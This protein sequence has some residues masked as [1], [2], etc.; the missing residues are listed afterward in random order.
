MLYDKKSDNELVAAYMN[1]DKQAFEVLLSRHKNKVYNYILSLVKDKALADD[2]FRDTHIKIVNTL[3]NGTY[4]D[5]GK[6]IQW[7]MRIA[8]NLVID[9]FRRSQRFPTVRTD[10]NFD[11]F[12][13]LGNSEESIEQKIIREQI[14]SDVKKLIRQ[15]PE[16]QRKVLIMRHYSNMS[17]K[18]IADK[19]DV[20]INT[21]L[22]RMRY[23]LINLRRMAEEKTTLLHM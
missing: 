15:L 14:N 13:V 20:S 7:V 8:H 10:E 19:T 18:D 23:A 17:F 4:R 3:R 11:I 2:I 9:H 16:E 22:G 5:E 21:A 1:D 12:D 6:Y